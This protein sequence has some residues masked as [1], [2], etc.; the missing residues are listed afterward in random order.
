MGKPSE[1]YGKLYSV[2]GKLYFLC[3]IF[4]YEV[5]GKFLP[6]LLK[7]SQ[8]LVYPP[9]SLLGNLVQDNLIFVQKKIFIQ[10]VAENIFG[11]HLTFF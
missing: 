3:D 2:L 8:N 1:T 4:L 7:K 5:G 6:F 11:Y 10:A 9:Q